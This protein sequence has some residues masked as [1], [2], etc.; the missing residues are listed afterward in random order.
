MGEPVPLSNAKSLEE[1]QKLILE[2]LPQVRLLAR[3]IHA[4]LPESVSLDDLQ[5]DGIL[6][7]IYAVDHFDPNQNVRL[8][9]FA[10]RRI[11]GSIVDGL[12]AR[13]CTPRLQRKRAR[14][15]E[16]AA[17]R[18]E[19]RLGR[20]AEEAELAAEMELSINE[21]RRKFVATQVVRM[22]DLEC[23]EDDSHALQFLKFAHI[24]KERV[25]D[26]T[27]EWSDL[28]RRIEAAI[29]AMPSSQK[30]VV[31]LYFYGGWTLREIA[32][33]MGVQISRVAH[34]K[35]AAILHLRKVLGVDTAAGRSG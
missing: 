15:F 32:Q 18:L 10:E 16:S 14:E 29:R 6:G 19:Q 31:G 30:T 11:R 25:P 5:S 33:L 35:T 23:L 20:R 9:T 24:S 4:R 13:D 28:A 27:F 2:N 7:L 3:K 22:V 21:Y 17:E 8:N 12:R 1:R 34:I 26:V